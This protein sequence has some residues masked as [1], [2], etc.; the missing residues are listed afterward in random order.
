MYDVS[1]HLGFLTAFQLGL[2]PVEFWMIW[3]KSDTIPEYGHMSENTYGKRQSSRR[4][5]QSMDWVG[6]V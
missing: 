6:N 3:V 2:K 5:D 4:Q 1:Q